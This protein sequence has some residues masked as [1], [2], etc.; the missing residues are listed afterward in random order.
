MQRMLRALTGA[1]LI[2]ALALPSHALAWGGRGHRL[3]GDLAYARL[4]PEGKALVDRLITLSPQQE[5]AAACPVKTLADVST[6]PDCVRGNETLKSFGYMSELH[7]VNRPIH[8]PAPQGSFCAAGNCVT[9][10]VRRAELVLVD[11]GAPDLVRLLAL[12]QL[13]HFMEDMHQP[14]HAGDNG[15]K[16]GNDVIILPLQGGGEGRGPNFTNLHSLWDGELVNAAVGR[17]LERI[18]TVRALIDRHAS[19]W[20]GQT[21]EQ[22]AAESWLISRDYAYACLPIPPRPGQSRWF[23]GQITQAYIDGVVPLVRVQIARAAV[24]L[25]NAINR[26]ARF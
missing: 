1:A 8:L 22:M 14:L 25:A 2:L 26:A 11:R 15:D 23:S 16:G 5:G 20:Q 7:Y 18:D 10:A 19:E 13:A 24:R 9:E 4:T 12:E 17:D 3:I 6:W 21:I